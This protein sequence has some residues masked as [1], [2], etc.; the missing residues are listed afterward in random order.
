MTRWTIDTLTTA[1][2]WLG[3][4]VVEDAIVTITADVR[5][6][7]CI[8]YRENNHLEPD[9]GQYLHICDL[10]GYIGML[11]EIVEEAEKHFGKNWSEDED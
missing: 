7:G 2:H 9:Q 11:Q 8:H 6:D 3:L 4:A 10:R 5:S 1:D